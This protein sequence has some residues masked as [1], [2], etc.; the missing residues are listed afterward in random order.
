MTTLRV[1]LNATVLALILSISSTSHSALVSETV[2]VA[3]DSDGD[4]LTD[5]IDPYPFDIFNGVYPFDDGFDFDEDG[6]PDWI[7]PWLLDPLN[8]DLES[9]SNPFP[10]LDFDGDGIFNDDDLFPFDPT[11]GPLDEDEFDVLEEFGGPPSIE[12][13]QIAPI[14]D[15][16]EFPLDDE[17]WE[18]LETLD[19]PPED[20]S[21]EIE[22]EFDFPPIEIPPPRVILPEFEYFT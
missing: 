11:F 21:I 13:P 7:D 12:P 4:G 14:P 22:I 16:N 8:V 1:L 5:D 6:L 20:E 2:P 10:D 17:P 18:D 3:G 9:N 15:P 19:D